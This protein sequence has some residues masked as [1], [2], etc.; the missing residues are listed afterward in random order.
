[1]STPVT[2]AQLQTLLRTVP[3]TRLIDVRTPAEFGS[4]HVPGSTN[5]P[6]ADLAGYRTALTVSSAAPV[7]LMCTSG[8]RAKRAEKQLADAGLARVHVLDGGV[9]AWRAAG[10]ELTQVAGSHGWSIE[11]QVRGVAGGIVLAS[12]LAGIAA[13]D[14]RYVAGA[15]G[16]GLLFSALTDTCALGTLLGRL[17]FNRGV[18]S[19][20]VPGAPA[21]TTIQEGPA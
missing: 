10:S 17:P 15:I 9:E 12:I 4:G 8:Q 13:P 1:M 7:V 16:A 11:R 14:A 3:G 21:R 19:C 5:V 18:A 2:S 20:T 6:L